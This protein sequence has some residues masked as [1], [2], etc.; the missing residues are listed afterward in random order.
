MR[1]VSEIV[2]VVVLLATQLADVVMKYN[3]L[4]DRC[5]SLELLVAPRT[6]IDSDSP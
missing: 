2:S 6:G 1:V 3:V 4:V 5:C